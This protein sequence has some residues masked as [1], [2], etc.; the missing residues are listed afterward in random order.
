MLT[1]VLSRRLRQVLLLSLLGWMV[2]SALFY[3]SVRVPV[4]KQGQTN[5]EGRRV[6][7]M[8]GDPQHPT[9]QIEQHPDHLCLIIPVQRMEALLVV[10][11]VFIAF[12]GVFGLLSVCLFLAFM[13][14]NPT[15]SKA[16]LMPISLLSISFLIWMLLYEYYWY[17]DGKEVITLTDS[18]ISLRYDLY[19]EGEPTILPLSRVRAIR[20]SPEN[21]NPR[22]FFTHFETGD[23]AIDY[24]DHTYRFG[25]NLG[26]EQAE[27]VVRALDSYRAQNAKPV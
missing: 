10:L 16:W 12:V 3:G 20:V 6:E 14:L 15:N 4:G 27:S 7:T 13:V 5:T 19:K 1:R 25:I 2:I 9:V 22:Y 26:R 11:K 21:H 23:I 17:R 24:G 18:T 8:P